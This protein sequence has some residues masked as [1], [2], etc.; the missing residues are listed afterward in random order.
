MQEALVECGWYNYSL[1]YRPDGFAIGYYETDN[2]DHATSCARMAKMGVNTRWQEA[3]KKYTAENVRPDEAMMTLEHYFYLGDNKSTNSN[4][5]EPT[6]NEAIFDEFTPQKFTGGGG[7]TKDG[8]RRICFQMK[9][10]T[11]NL[12]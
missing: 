9:F 8:R 12:D 7:L 10:D 6:K 3:M 4:Q 5:D 2:A 1:F 11:T